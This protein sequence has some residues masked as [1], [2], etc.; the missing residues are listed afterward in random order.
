MA[1]VRYASQ[2]PS[3]QAALTDAK[4]TGAVVI[5]SDYSGT[6]TFTN[7]NNVQVIDLRGDASVIEV[8]TTS[9]ILVQFQTTIGMIF[10]LSKRPSMRLVPVPVHSAPCMCQKALIV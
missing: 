2:F 10:K 6:D 3:I 7:P 9:E 4:T 5:P 1:G 8:Y